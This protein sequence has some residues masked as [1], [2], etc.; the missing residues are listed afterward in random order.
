MRLQDVDATKEDLIACA[1]HEAQLA[2]PWPSRSK[3][4]FW[5]SRVC[6]GSSSLPQQWTECKGSTSWPWI[7]E[8]N[9]H[10]SG[11]WI[12]SM[13]SSFTCSFFQLQRLG[14]IHSYSCTIWEPCEAHRPS[15]LPSRTLP[16]RRI[17]LRNGWATFCNWF[18][19]CTA[20]IQEEHGGAQHITT[21]PPKV[22]F[23]GPEHL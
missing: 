10:F 9:C 23:D 13:T 8:S 5:S 1:A 17:R 22:L 18:C 14:T 6:P 15:T 2:Q 20:R 4:P 19:N 12:H 11:V 21:R 7:V 16:T 3:S